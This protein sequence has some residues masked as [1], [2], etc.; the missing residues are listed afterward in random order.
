MTAQR[1]NFPL[2]PRDSRKVDSLHESTPETQSRGSGN[3][4]TACPV[5]RQTSVRAPPLRCRTGKALQDRRHC[6]RGEPPGSPP[7]L[8][9]RPPMDSSPYRSS[10]TKRISSSEYAMQAADG[11][12]H[13]STGFYVM[14]KPWSSD[15]KTGFRKL[16]RRRDRRRRH[17]EGEMM[18]MHIPVDA[19]R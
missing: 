8:P 4:E 19:E 13:G 15:S 18:H 10:T 14:I 17:R 7:R 6:G 9:L 12:P 5:R 2:G 3:K 16:M 1:D 11:S